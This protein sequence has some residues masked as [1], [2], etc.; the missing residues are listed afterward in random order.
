VTRNG[1]STDHTRYDI[2]VKGEYFP[3][4]I[5]LSYMYTLC[6]VYYRVKH[7]KGQCCVAVELKIQVLLFLKATCFL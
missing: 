3:D 5:E 6:I 4:Q 1:V 2:S 7:N